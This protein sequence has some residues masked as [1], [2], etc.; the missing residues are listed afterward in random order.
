MAK[1]LLV[2]SCGL[3]LLAGC[4]GPGYQGFSNNCSSDFISDYN[5][6]AR[7]AGYVTHSDVA[8]VRSLAN[9]LKAKYP[10]VRCQAVNLSSSSLGSDETT[11]DVDSAMNDLISKLDAFEKTK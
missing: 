11:V 4:G 9:S 10:G 5:K 7:S 3:F 8:S 1:R 2:A 6:V